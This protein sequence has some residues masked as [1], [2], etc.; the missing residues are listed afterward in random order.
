MISCVI[1]DNSYECIKKTES[2]LTKFPFVKLLNSFVNAFEALSYIQHNHIDI[3][4]TNVELQGIS[5]LDVLPSLINKPLIIFTSENDKYTVEAFKIQAI[6]YLVKPFNYARFLKA[7]YRCKELHEVRMQKSHLHILQTP[8]IKANLNYILIK[9]EYDTIKIYLKD[10][11]YLEGLKDYVRITTSEGNFLTLNSLKNF[12]NKLPTNQFIRI[13]R[14][15]IV[16]I[17]NLDSIE[18]NQ[19]IIG[20]KRIKLGD[21]YKSSFLKLI[22]QNLMT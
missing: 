15:F 4:I 8:S 17:N 10:I 16:S 18:R 2:Y 6:D 20:N 3:I 19:V 1:I 21:N 13:H 9:V 12:S 11:L 5:A 14:S 22:D 7:I